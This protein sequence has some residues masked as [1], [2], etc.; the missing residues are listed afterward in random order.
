MNLPQS[1]IART[2]V[3]TVGSNSSIFTSI[4]T[5]PTESGSLQILTVRSDD[6]NQTQK[7]VLGRVFLMERKTK[8]YIGLM[9]VIPPRMAWI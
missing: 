9:A 8:K 1:S 3:A 2:Q 7:H 5:Q 4:R 6:G